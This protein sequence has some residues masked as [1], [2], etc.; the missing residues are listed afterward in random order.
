MSRVTVLVV[1]VLALALLGAGI[2][3]QRLSGPSY[4]DALQADPEPQLFSAAQV[5]QVPAWIDPGR[6]RALHAIG[7]WFAQHGTRPHDAAF[8]SWLLDQVP[9]PPDSLAGQQATVDRLFRTRT[10]AGVRAATWLEAHGKK[11]LWKLAAHD[12][13]ELLSPDGEQR[14]KATE[15]SMLRFTKGVAD[16]LG[17]RYGSSAP[18]V[19]EP[20]LRPEKHIRHGQRCPCSWPSRHAAVAAASAMLLGELQPARAPEYRSLERQVDFSRVYMGGHF[21]GDLGAGS[22]LGTLVGCYYLVTR[23]G[24]AADRLVSPTRRTP[25]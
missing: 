12:Q 3:A 14:L 16:E 18:Y 11:D 15:K 5:A 2:V 25:R 21:P 19:R 9:A 13:G 7:A 10:P 24:F 6:D 17:A 22:Y 1:A 23:E 4:R 8:R 20:S